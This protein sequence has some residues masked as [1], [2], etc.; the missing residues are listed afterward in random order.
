MFDCLCSHSSEAVAWKSQYANN[1]HTQAVDEMNQFC[2]FMKEVI[3]PMMPSG[4][5]SVH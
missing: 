5:L 4:F 2:D 1:L 3:L